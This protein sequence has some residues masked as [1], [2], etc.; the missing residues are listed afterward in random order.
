MG[1]EAALRRGQER[2]VDSGWQLWTRGSWTLWPLSSPR[3]ACFAVGGWHLENFET[4]EESLNCLC[5][6]FSWTVSCHS[7][8]GCGVCPP[9]CLVHYST[10]S[11]CHQLPRP[12]SQPLC[13]EP[14][15]MWLKI[16]TRGLTDRLREPIDF[17]IWN[18]LIFLVL[19]CKFWI[20]DIYVFYLI[21]YIQHMNWWE[22]PI[23]HRL[24][25]YLF[26]LKKRW[27]L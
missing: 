6:F 11:P 26:P 22:I 13:S 17:V 4:V 5:L 3:A 18:A 1:W 25:N 21:T 16:V 15:V 2:T 14:T 20:V 12:E 27:E 9:E 19:C 24:K 23:F 8:R 10:C 7:L